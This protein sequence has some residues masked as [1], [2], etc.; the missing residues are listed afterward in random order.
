MSISAGSRA[1]SSTT[2][3]DSSG[4]STS[5]PTITGVVG[6]RNFSRTSRAAS[7]CQVRERLA[8]L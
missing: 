3:T 7:T 2:R 6:S 4:P 8:G 5:R 1:P